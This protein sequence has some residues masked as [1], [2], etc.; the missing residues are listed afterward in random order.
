VRHTGTRG[1]I[2][3]QLLQ[4]HPDVATALENSKRIPGQIAPHQAAA[5]YVLA[6]QYNR[7]G[8][9]VLEIGTFHGYSASIIAQAAPLAEIVTLNP[10]AKE[11]T[12]AIK[13]LAPWPNVTVGTAASWDYMEG[14]R[15]PRL[16]MIFVDGDHKHIWRDMPWWAWV[17]EG[18]LMLFHDYSP[19]LCRPVY[20]A[21][22]RLGEMLG[23]EPDVLVM[24]DDGLGMAGFYRQPED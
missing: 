10:S 9:H 12:L 24:D 8:A 21:V 4:E 3:R 1:D 15:S 11:A 22:G 17:E 14:Y 7:R 6:G 5:L 23:R 16:D 19:R 13:N 20:A 2:L 18:G